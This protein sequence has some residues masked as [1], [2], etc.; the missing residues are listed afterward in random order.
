LLESSVSAS[1]SKVQHHIGERELTHASCVACMDTKTGSRRGREG[2]GEGALH[3]RSF[4]ELRTMS[5]RDRHINGAW[6][7]TTYTT[8]T[9]LLVNASNPG[10]ASLSVPA[11]P[12]V[13]Y[14]GLSLL[15]PYH[16]SPLRLIQFVHGRHTRR[17]SWRVGGGGRLDVDVIAFVSRP[18]RKTTRSECC[19]T[20]SARRWE[21]QA[22]N[23]RERGD[24]R[25]M[26]CWS[27]SL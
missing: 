20:R 4:P 25:A 16:R 5:T 21:A 27:H 9:A 17:C 19:R 23:G 6:T 14:T 7:Y 12:S 24:R 3:I 15:P 8:A 22:D 1:A 13:R 10:S 2:I 18:W 11:H 26:S